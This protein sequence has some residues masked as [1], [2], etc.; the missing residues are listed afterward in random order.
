MAA[1]STQLKKSLCVLLALSLTLLAGCSGASRQKDPNAITVAVV[2]RDGMQYDAARF[3]KGIDLA[4]Q[5]YKGECSVNVMIFDSSTSIE[6]AQAI[7]TT[8]AED[9]DITAVVTLQD[10]EEIDVTAQT[11][12]ENNKTYFAVEG[13]L[14]KTVEKEYETF[15]PFSLD[16]Q[17]LGYAMGVY[18]GEQKLTRTAVMHSGTEF[19]I[20]QA[21]YFESGLLA[22]DGATF[23]S[24]SA[25]F[26]AQDFR[27]YTESMHAIQVDALYVPF[28]NSQFGVEY[29]GVVKRLLP[30]D[31]NITYLASF[32]LG[33]E[34]TVNGLASLEGTIV[35]AFYPVDRTSEYASWESRYEAAYG[36]IP[37][38]QAVQGY[39]LMNLI[40]KNYTGDNSTLAQNIRAN[41]KKTE[42]IA[43]DITYDLINGL[44]S[45]VAPEDNYY[46]YLVISDSKF[47]PVT[48]G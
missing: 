47:V 20:T 46:E 38:N 1:V 27:T 35:P 44:P 26:S 17:H 23:C 42:G 15:F 19:E 43:G 45:S 2:C 12:D 41:A 8:L 10:Y 36:E 31:S 16:A 28:Y 7:D 13:Y 3:Q 5:E 34:A 48:I 25:P 9:P 21:N 37:E 32:T 29:I 14:D 24:I 4:I 33:S 11:M 6:E 22:Y 39:D 40:L 30:E 18:A